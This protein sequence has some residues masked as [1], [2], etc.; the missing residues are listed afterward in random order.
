MMGTLMTRKREEHEMNFSDK[1]DETTM[2]QQN[3]NPSLSKKWK[4]IIGAMLAIFVVALIIVVSLVVILP[5]TNSTSGTND[6]SKKLAGKVSLNNDEGLY[7]E[8][9]LL[10]PSQKSL[11]LLESDITPDVAEELLMRE[12]DPTRFLTSEVIE[13]LAKNCDEECQQKK[14]EI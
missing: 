5:K 3:S 7:E 2:T 10:N 13:K 14:S 8:F 9:N 12:D 11:L 4:M 6:F 1:P